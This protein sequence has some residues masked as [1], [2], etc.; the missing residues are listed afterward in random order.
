MLLSCRVEKLSGT[1]TM[2]TFTPVKEEKKKKRIRTL[3]NI[4]DFEKHV[5]KLVTNTEVF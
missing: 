1:V 2:L 3:H 5:L 4:K